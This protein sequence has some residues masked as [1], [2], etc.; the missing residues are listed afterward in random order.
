MGFRTG[1]YA[2]IWS[3]ERTDND[4][5]TK[6]KLTTRKKNKKTDEWE[7]DFSGFCRFVGKAAKEAAELGE[8]DKIKIG[9]CDVT[10]VYDKK[11]G[12]EY[13][14]F[15]VFSFESLDSSSSE[16]K[17]ADPVDEPCDGSTDGLPF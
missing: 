1:A 16:S 7:T 13:V 11:A 12:R 4:N 17:A 8:K 9:D 10:A 15:V 14:N 2:T 6:V 5:V 3:V